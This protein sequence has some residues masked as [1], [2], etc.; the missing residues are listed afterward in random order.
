LE[1]DKEKGKLHELE[2]AIMSRPAVVIVETPEE[3]RF[4]SELWTNMS[5]TSVIYTAT[6]ATGLREVTSS[7]GF[8]DPP[9][10]PEGNTEENLYPTEISDIIDVIRN[11]HIVAAAAVQSGKKIE[12]PEGKRH[13]LYILR[14][15]N[16]SA[17]NERS[18]IHLKEVIPLMYRTKVFP[19]II[20]FVTHSVNLHPL[21]EKD[22]CVYRH[23]L[24]KRKDVEKTVR[25]YIKAFNSDCNTDPNKIVWIDGANVPIK[26]AWGFVKDDS[27][28]YQ[29]P[30]DDEQLYTISG[31][32]AGLSKGEIELA[33]RQS[34]RVTGRLDPDRLGAQKCEILKK[35]DL[36]ELFP[37][38]HA[39]D[40]KDVGGLD[41]LKDWIDV[42]SKTFYSDAARKF[43]CP[44]P[45]GVMLLGPP[46]IGSERAHT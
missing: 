43:G 31:A 30:Y 2:V 38:D 40:M 21:I 16:L 34:M 9:V 11:E 18:V 14:S 35:T 36:L 19:S 28:K 33:I 4:L 10:I 24:L 20:I 46:G 1:K 45:K 42:K 5:R 12:S 44:P 27:G 22:V 7:D 6:P 8:Y 26:D 37:A 39:P 29:L 32:L 25:L 17:D 15:Y 13:K 3:E 41:L 23:P